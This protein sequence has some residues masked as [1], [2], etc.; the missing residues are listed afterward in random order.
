MVETGGN[1][2]SPRAGAR[3]LAGFVAAYALFQFAANAFVSDRGQAGILIALLVV[4]ALILVEVSLFATSLRA[5]PRIL[6]LGIPAS[7]GMAAATFLGAALF[8]LIPAFAF[9]SQIK[10]AM[11]SGWALMLPGLFAQ[12][13]IAEETLFRGYLFGRLRRGRKFWSAAFLSSLPFTM[14]HMVLFLVLP[15]PLALASVLLAVATSFPLAHLFVIGGNT[16]WAP[17]VLHFVV[18]GGLKIVSVPEAQASTLALIWFGGAALL[19]YLAFLVP[20]PH[21]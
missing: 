10:L 3:L 17:A 21:E 11:M 8:A 13:G 18:Q 4:A 5:A 14:A 20:R 15:W 6:G 12:A 2:D 19:P 16:I 9:L 7:T 1:I